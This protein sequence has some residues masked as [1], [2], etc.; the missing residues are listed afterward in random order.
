MQKIDGKV[1]FT[2]IEEI[3]DPLHSALVVLDVQNTAVDLIFNKDE[4]ITNIISLIHS[5]REKKIPVLYSKIQYVPLKYQSPAWIYTSNKLITRPRSPSE[6]GLSLAVQ[7]AQD[8]IVI[9]R[10][11]SGIIIDTASI[12][13]GTEFERMVRNADINTLIFTGIA[14]ELGIESNARESLNRDFYTVVVSDAVSSFDR[15]S[16]MRSLENMGKLITILPSTALVNNWSKI[17][18]GSD[19]GIVSG[20][21]IQ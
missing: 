13:I 11:A 12:F 5:A 6:Q 17:L 3:V 15:E 19:G 14:T 10:R 4:F 18:D 21:A 7:P 8:E 20:G 9:N 16:H 1:I 2:E